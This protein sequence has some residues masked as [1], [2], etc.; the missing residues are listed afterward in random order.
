MNSF[1]WKSR[2]TSESE[3]QLTS[4]VMVRSDPICHRPAWEEGE[5]PE[6]HVV[7]GEGVWRGAVGHP[8]DEVV[9]VVDGIGFLHGAKGEE[10]QRRQNSGE[11]RGGA[12][13]AKDLGRSQAAPGAHQRFPA[14]PCRDRQQRA[15]C[16]CRPVSRL[17]IGGKI[18]ELRQMLSGGPAE[19]AAPPPTPP[20]RKRR[21]L[22]AAG[23]RAIAE[24]QRKRWAGSKQQSAPP[25]PAAPEA[26]KPR[27]RISEEGMKRIIAATKKRW[28]LSKAAKVQP[29]AAKKA[30]PKKVAAK[31]AA[32]KTAAP[33]KAAPAVKKV[34]VKKAAAKA[35]AKSGEENCAREEGRSKG[36]GSVCSTRGG[37]CRLSRSLIGDGGP[38]E[39]R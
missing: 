36:S 22:S 12:R 25:A 11:Q 16:G 28:R 38:A 3:D 21:K 26:P 27:R 32:P 17:S 34:A 6:S 10:N 30:A 31:K 5:F 29:A 19:P 24:A 1:E 15:Q 18:A 8:V 33:K 35:P 39:F 14:P 13:V 7:G 20:K 23:R 9:Q 2:M 4:P 37:N